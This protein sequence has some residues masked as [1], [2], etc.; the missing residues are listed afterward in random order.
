MEQ[1]LRQ[2]NLA[3]ADSEGALRPHADSLEPDAAPLVHTVE[4]A[5]RILRVGRSLAYALARRYLDTDGR[6]GL[7]VLRVGSCL[8]VPRWALLELVHTGRTVSLVASS[9]PTAERTGSPHGDTRSDGAGQQSP[10]RKRGRRTNP[11]IRAEVRV[12][13]SASFQDRVSG[14]SRFR[15]THRFPF[16]KP[17]CDRVWPNA[18]DIHGASEDAHSPAIH[19][20]PRRGAVTRAL[21]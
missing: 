4:E 15:D 1:E 20:G 3:T 17:V 7:P 5:A 6:D 11:S 10:R 21:G 8:R 9:A 16:G 2:A 19:T 14:L 12:T 18:S 13:R